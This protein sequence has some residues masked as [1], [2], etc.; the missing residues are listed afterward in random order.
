MKGKK[1]GIALAGGGARGAYQVGALEVLK[2]HGYLDNVHAISGVSVG[3]LNACLLAME[4]IDLAE[5]LWLNL[6]ENDLFDTDVNWFEVL[7]KQNFK[8]LHEGVFDTD[9]LEKI[10]D[11]T[12]DFE[13]IKTKNVFV[14]TAYVTD[15]DIGLLDTLTLGIKNFFEKD[16]RVTYNH[17]KHM[18]NED[19]KTTLLASCAVPI[20]FKPIKIKGKTY[21]DGGILDNASFKPLIEAGCD[22]IIFIDLWRFKFRHFPRKK[23]ING[24]KIHHIYPRKNLRG[25]MDF[26][27]DRIEERF[28]QGKLDAKQAI[29]QWIK[30]HEA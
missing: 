7:F 19:I 12:I 10:I 23:T 17:L 1:I 25:I 14:T 29:N 8:L 9:R 30:S 24:V 15:R 5:T 18:S 4:R 11:E 21:Y 13:A 27:H 3:S 20:M 28:K 22:E 16:G 6:K 2:A 26:N